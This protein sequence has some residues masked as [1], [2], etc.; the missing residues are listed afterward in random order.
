[1][2]TSLR[3][4]FWITS[5]HLVNDSD[6]PLFDIE[7]VPDDF[8]LSSSSS[9]V[10]LFYVKLKYMARLL[11]KL[12]GIGPYTIYKFLCK[13]YRTSGTIQVKYFSWQVVKKV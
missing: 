12:T 6:D 13:K 4:K 8:A 7:D 1:M 3:I 11:I 2:Q 9:D 10:F 5:C